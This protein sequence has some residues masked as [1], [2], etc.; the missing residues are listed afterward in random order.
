M[1][2]NGLAGEAGRPP[3]SPASNSTLQIPETSFIFGIAG[4]S[5]K[6]GFLNDEGIFWRRDGICVPRKQRGGRAVRVEL[7]LS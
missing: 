3:D 6:A 4:R 7:P 1:A 2:A 5:K